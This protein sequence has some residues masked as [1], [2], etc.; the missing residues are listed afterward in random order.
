[1]K[2]TSNITHEPVQVHEGSKQLEACPRTQRVTERATR[3]AGG[4]LHRL[5]W[6]PRRRP[7]AKRPL[8]F[9]KFLIWIW[10]NKT[11]RIKPRQNACSRTKRSPNNTE[12]DRTGWK[13]TR[14]EVN[15][16]SNETKRQRQR[17][18][19]THTCV[20][21][22]WWCVVVR[23]VIL[24]FWNLEAPDGIVLTMNNGHVSVADRQAWVLRGFF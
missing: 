22:F 14:A 5:G 7:L 13:H 12:S 17:A 15:K 10:M 20:R 3:K 9:P 8:L 4:A 23:R 21:W 19:L 11:K 1:M 18:G 16:N 24:A 6:R 2:K